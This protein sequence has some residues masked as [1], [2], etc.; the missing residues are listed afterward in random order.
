MSNPKK[1]H[2]CGW[3]QI[4]HEHS[5]SKHQIHANLDGYSRQHSKLLVNLEERNKY[6]ILHIAATWSYLV[7]PL[8]MCTHE[9]FGLRKSLNFGSLSIWVFLLSQIKIWTTTTWSNVWVVLPRPSW[10]E[11]LIGFLVWTPASK[12]LHLTT[13]SNI[14]VILS[15]F[16][17]I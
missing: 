17:Y 12:Y 7:W 16:L 9:E 15:M 11:F 1:H 14:C 3:V 4:Q 5:N 13:F 6:C 2:I 10:Y 8:H